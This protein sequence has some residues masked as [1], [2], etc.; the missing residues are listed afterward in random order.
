MLRTLFLGFIRIH[1]LFHAAEGP[2]YGASLMAELPRHGY[3]VG[4]GTLYPILHG[5]EHQGFLR[6]EQCV[7]RGK[8]RKYYRITAA[9]RRLL[10]RARRQLREL[11]QE[12]LPS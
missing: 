11:V 6:Q 8:V 5:L 3:R 10:A 1:I 12:V 7:V 4:P 2:V 9:G